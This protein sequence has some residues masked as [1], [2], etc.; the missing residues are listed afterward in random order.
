[1][2]DPR[3]AL[4]LTRPAAASQRFAD[5]F[6]AR[7]GADWPIV[8]SPLMETRLLSP[9]LPETPF[10]HVAFTSETAVAAYSR[11]TRDRT[12]TT[13]CVG[14]RTAQAAQAAGFAARQGQGDAETLIKLIRTERPAGPFLWPH[15]AHLARDLAADLGAAGFDVTSLQVYA[16]RAIGPTAEAMAL[17]AGDSPVLLP[18][19]SP[20]SARLAADAFAAHVA[21][22]RVA[23]LS[24]AVAKAAAGLSPERLSIARTPESECLLDALAALI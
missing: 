9:D 15:G 1:M 19:F 14:Q 6:R 16:Q 3:P 13:W 24:Q 12:P 10:A 8:I 2:N 4:L 20:R 17:L 23:A 21:P 7:F 11:L 18:L 5:G 22:I